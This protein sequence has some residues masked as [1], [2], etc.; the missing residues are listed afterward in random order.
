MQAQRG[1]AGQSQLEKLITRGPRA[2][3]QQD[4][5]QLHSPSC[6]TEFLLKDANGIDKTCGSEGLC[7]PWGREQY[8][9]SLTNGRW[10]KLVASFG[11]EWLGTRVNY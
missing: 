2:P 6:C 10:E 7:C 1:R 4:W 9:Y 8:P 3:G 11:G 5:P